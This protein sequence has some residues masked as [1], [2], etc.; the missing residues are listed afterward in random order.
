MLSP[1]LAVGL[2][3]APRIGHL[4]TLLS[5][6]IRSGCTA[7]PRACWSVC[8]PWFVLMR[9][10]V[11]VITPHDTPLW[12]SYSRRILGQC[13]TPHTRIQEPDQRQGWRQRRSTRSPDV[14]LA[15][16]GWR[17]PAPLPLTE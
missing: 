6:R 8:S 7:V 14:L 10:S 9:L 16:P 11:P 4:S 3:T 5:S 12:S 17:Q 15:S 13:F 1:Y 2:R